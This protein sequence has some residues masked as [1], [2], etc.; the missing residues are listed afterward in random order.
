MGG[1]GG[2]GRGLAAVRWKGCKGCGEGRGPPPLLRGPGARHVGSR[3]RRSCV[4]PRTLLVQ[5]LIEIL[6]VDRLVG[7]D[8]LRTA[9]TTCARRGE[10]ECA[11][12]VVGGA[13]RR[14]A[15]APQPVIQAGSG[16]AKAEGL[17]LVAPACRG[18]RLH[19][20]LP[21]G[22]AL[23]RAPS[24]PARPSSCLKRPQEGPRPD[25][26]SPG[27]ERTRVEPARTL[28]MA[29]RAPAGLA[30]AARLIWLDLSARDPAK[31][32]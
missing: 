9:A 24:P 1:G 28:T 15:A 3:R 25:S 31:S 2:G 29:A 19:V 21:A 20:A 22:T 10:G 23:R 11:A 30:T 17:L 6:H 18:W 12:C 5:L 26:A 8:V 13:A 14:W 7:R 27:P 32:R 16:A 4:A